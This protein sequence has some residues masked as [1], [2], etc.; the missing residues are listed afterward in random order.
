MADNYLEK[1][2]EEYRLR[3]ER[4]KKAKTLAW[5]KRMDAYKKKLEEESQKKQD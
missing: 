3:K 2:M 1:R 5:R 4:E